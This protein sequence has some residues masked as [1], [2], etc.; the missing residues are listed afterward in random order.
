M[1]FQ[2]FIV[3]VPIVE[4]VSNTRMRDYIRDAVSSWSGQF[5]PNDDPL[6]DAFRCQNPVTVKRLKKAQL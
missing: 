3:R 2:R 5:D 6:F 1:K 4:G